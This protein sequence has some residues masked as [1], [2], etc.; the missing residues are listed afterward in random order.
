MSSEPTLSP[1]PS[2]PTD[3]GDELACKY[4]GE[5]FATWM[6]SPEQLMA[7]TYRGPGL[8]VTAGYIRYLQNMVDDN[9]V[10]DGQ[11]L[12]W[13]ADTQNQAISEGNTAYQQFIDIVIRPALDNCGA[14]VCKSL[15]WTGN[16]D[17]AGIG[18]SSEPD[19]LLPGGMLTTPFRFSRHITWKP[20]SQRYTSSSY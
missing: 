5:F 10:T 2:W 9:T 8:D 11:L 3:V 18:V 7:K 17:L 20:P 4:A 13:F 19:H 6:T 1:N 15:G 12:E 16:G 14:S